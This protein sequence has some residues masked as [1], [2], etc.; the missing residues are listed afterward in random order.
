[1]LSC[2]CHCC[3]IDHYAYA[4]ASQRTS[5][6]RCVNR[7]ATPNCRDAASILAAMFTCGDKY[8]A[9]TFWSE[10][11]APSIAHP[12]C[13]PKPMRRLNT[14]DSSANRL[15]SRYPRICLSLFTSTKTLRNPIS[16]LSATMSRP[17]DGV[18]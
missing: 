11:T 2:E 7:M 12:A 15:S 17:I 4:F 6:N 18:V 9:S 5:K 10:P 1:M 13:K 14:P 8:V 3:S 16:A